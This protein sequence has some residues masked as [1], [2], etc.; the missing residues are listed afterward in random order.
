MGRSSRNSLLT[1]SR[2]FFAMALSDASF[3]AVYVF[4]VKDRENC[5]YI[6]RQNR[7]NLAT[8]NILF[9]GIC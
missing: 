9:Y 7:E 6:F 3:G 4:R 8:P 5:P 2:R 1:V